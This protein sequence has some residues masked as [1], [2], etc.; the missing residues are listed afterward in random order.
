MVTSKNPS[1]GGEH[2]EYDHEQIELAGVLTHGEFD[3]NRHVLQIL[4]YSPVP[5]TQ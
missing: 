5:G 2:V 4:T 3:G 1:L